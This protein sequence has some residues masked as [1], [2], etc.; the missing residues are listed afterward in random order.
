MA[1]YA[2]GDIQGCLVPLEELL[3]QIEFDPGIDRIWFCGDLI[4][5]GP[6]S[7]ETLRFVKSLGDSAVT[8]L[9]NH[10]LHLLAIA[11]GFKQERP[12]DTYRKILKAPD[13][14]ELLFWLRQ[15]PLVHF[16]KS[17]KTLLVHAGVFPGWSRKQLKNYAREIEEHLRGKR[18][19][20]YL[21]RMYGRHP[22]FWDDDMPKWQRIRFI[23]NALTRM[24]YCDTKGR[25]NL[26]SKG[27]P[28]SQQKKLVPWFEHPRLKCKKW[29]I[30]CGHWSAL[31]LINEGRILSL[32][33]GCVW[34]GKLTAAELTREKV[35]N[36]EQVRCLKS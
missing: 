27:P 18:Y 15:R 20:R 9:G 31:G 36:I 6:H 11:E 13:A 10:D 35:K 34:G 8:V 22:M 3:D 29:R 28:G 32:D 21:K 4:N 7:L 14:E 30:V 16:D 2:I 17:L 5:R 19:R 1:T 24:R 33:T 23:T 26:T 25:L 12:G